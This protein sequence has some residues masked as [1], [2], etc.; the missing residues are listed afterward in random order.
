MSKPDLSYYLLQMIKKTKPLIFFSL[1]FFLTSCSFYSQPGIW[2]GGEEEKR[3]MTELIKEQKEQEVKKSI[4]FYSSLNPYSKEIL[5]IKKITLSEPVK[6][7]SWKMSGLNHQNFFGNIYLTGIDNNFLKKKIGKNKF[8]ISRIMLSPLSFKNNIFFSDDTGTIFN[9]NQKGK[10][11]WKKNIYKKM[12]KK[13]YKNLSLAIYGD[14]IYVSDNIGFIYAVSLASGKLIW[15]KNHGVP[16]K[17]KIKIFNNKIFLINQDN[18]ILCFSVDDG[19]K[20]WDVRTVASFIKSQS[21]LALAISKNGNVITLN[22]S[23]DLINT[24]SDNGRIFWNLNTIGSLF[25]HDTDF[26]TSSD[27]V[28]DGNDIIFSTSSTIFSIDL[29]S[30]YLNWKQ[31]IGS[32][33]NPII[34]GNN[35]FLI[36]DNG[37]FINLNKKSG[38]I[39]WSINILKVLKKKKQIT[40]I[41]GF[42][43]GSGKVYVTTLNGFVIV[44]SA[45]L[46]KVEYFK[47]IGDA[48]ISSPIINNDS[49]YILTEKSRIL[50]FN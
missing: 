47:K 22:S 25:S 44:C 35:V 17:S 49:L 45:T 37:Y 4:K 5:P 9:I 27:I 23:G 34:D 1:I 19:A 14:K 31:D 18:R 50:G 13:M 43:M 48:I 10:I 32:K 42:I 8:S 26:F 15:I 36:S 38:K 39:I 3:R 6:V 28:I 7:S 12:Y 40:Q 30:G 21:F 46:G 33:N 2:S 29:K 16:I 11:N 24:K 20:I 41:T